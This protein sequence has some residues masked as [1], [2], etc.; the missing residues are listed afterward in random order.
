MLASEQIEN[1]KEEI[2]NLKME[3]DTLGTRVY[4]LEEEKEKQEKSIE[5]ATVN[6]Y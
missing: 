3:I 1:L 6:I 5:V 4:E 2:T